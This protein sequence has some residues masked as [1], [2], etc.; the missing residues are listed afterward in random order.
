MKVQDLLRKK[1]GV[2]YSVKPDQT[3]YEAIEK[4]AN[5]N[6]GAL[7]VL[8]KGKLIGIISERDY[9]NKVILKGRTSKETPVKDIMTCELITVSP[10]DKIRTCMELMT[11]NRIRHL[12]VLKEWNVEGVISIGDVVKAVIQ[13]QKVEIDS[14]REYIS[15]G[16]MQ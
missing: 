14:L 2:V 9:R 3:V 16:Y 5:Y 6:V 12:P 1:D 11:E 4:M 10:Y 15:T 7:L 13:D 8:E